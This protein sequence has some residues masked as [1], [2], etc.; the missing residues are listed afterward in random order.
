MNVRYL[1]KTFTVAPG[2]NSAYRANYDAVFGVRC[3]Q[4]GCKG[5]VREG[6]CDACGVACNHG[7]VF[8][9]AAATGLPAAEVRR[10]WPRLS[11]RCP[12]G[13]GF[14][15]VAYASFQHMVEGDW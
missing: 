15:G 3:E 5:R 9:R 13:C 1:D 2:V 14:D 10:R 12:R 7:V 4:P 6:Q 11:G 8:D